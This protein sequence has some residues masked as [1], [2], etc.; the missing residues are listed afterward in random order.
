MQDRSEKI[1]KLTQIVLNKN[2]DSNEKNS[3]SPAY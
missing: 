3:N 1:G 2:N